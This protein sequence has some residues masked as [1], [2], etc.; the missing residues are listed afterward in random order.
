MWDIDG[1]LGYA[2]SRE[3]G[4]EMSIHCF[5][6]VSGEQKK[7]KNTALNEAILHSN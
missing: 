7:F 1:A 4:G 5:L 3:G 2:F 6:K